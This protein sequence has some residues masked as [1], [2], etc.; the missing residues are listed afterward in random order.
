VRESHYSLQIPPGWVF[1]ASWLSHAEVKPDEGSGNVLQ[2]VV[3]D[4]KGIR[5]EPD[6]PPLQGVA[7]QMIVSYFPSGGAARKNEFA[8]WEGMGSWRAN[9]Y[10][11]RMDASEAIKEK[12]SSLAAGKTTV[13]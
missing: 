7:G 9:L 12:V 10:S 2:W 13:R 4:V 11:G 3:N 8:N 6:M 5:L 1:K